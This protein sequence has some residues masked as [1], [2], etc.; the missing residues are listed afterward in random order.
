MTSYSADKLITYM[1]IAVT[2][3]A[4]MLY[5]DDTTAICG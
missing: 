5:P 1:D 2:E 4:A 3:V